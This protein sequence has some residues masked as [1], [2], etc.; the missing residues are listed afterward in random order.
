MRFSRAAWRPLAAG[1]PPVMARH[2]IVCLHT[3][4]GNLSGTDA[5]FKKNGWSGTESHFGIGGT[6]GDGKDGVIYQWVDTAYRADANLNGNHRVISIETGDNAPRSASDIAAW[7]PRQLD[8]IVLLVADLCQAHDIPA[9]LI[10]DT[11]P[12][13][14]GI[15]WHRQG[16][17]H[18]QGVGAVPG[19]LVPGGERWSTSTGKECPG[20]ARVAQMKQIETRVKAELAK[21]NAP[22]EDDMPTT[23]PTIGEIRAV[24][25]EELTRDQTVKVL[26]EKLFEADVIQAPDAEV[27]AHPE[28]P[29]WRLDSYL[30]HLVALARGTTPP[31]P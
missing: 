4:V 7:T 8:A 20:N 22:E 30:K 26:A 6:W 29:T 27:A 24:I 12:G 2:D 25:R 14:R 31:T 10:P 19:Y 3:M 1:H 11:K 16:V 17:E 28:N 18:S 5:L 23:G 21:R 15:G 9:V 13:R